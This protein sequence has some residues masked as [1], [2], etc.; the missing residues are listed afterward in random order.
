MQLPVIQYGD[1][2]TVKRCMRKITGSYDPYASQ[3]VTAAPQT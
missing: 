1:W 2:Q 3:D